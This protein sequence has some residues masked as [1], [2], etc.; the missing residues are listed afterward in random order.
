MAINRVPGGGSRPGVSSAGAERDA[1]PTQAQDE[2]E[3]TVDV[4]PIPNVEGSNGASQLRQLV[5]RAEQDSNDQQATLRIQDSARA[6]GRFEQAQRDQLPPSV[7]DSSL[8][9]QQQRDASDVQAL[10]QRA[11]GADAGALSLNDLQALIRAQE[12]TNASTS[13]AASGSAVTPTDTQQDIELANR[14]LTDRIEQTLQPRSAEDAWYE[15]GLVVSATQPMQHFVQQT[16]GVELRADSPPASA[17][18]IERTSGSSTRSLDLGN[19]DAVSGR[20][21]RND[22][23]A[24][25]NLGL[26]T[27]YVDPAHAVLE[28][29]LRTQSAS[30]SDNFE[31][32]RDQVRFH[33]A[34]RSAIRAEQDRALQALARLRDMPEGSLLSPPFVPQEIKVEWEGRNVSTPTTP[35]LPDFITV[36]IDKQT[37]DIPKAIYTKVG[38]NEALG[39]LGRV[40]DLPATTGGAQGCG[41]G[42]KNELVSNA[43]QFL[44]TNAALRTVQNGSFDYG[45]QGNAQMDYSAFV[46]ELERY[47][48]SAT[49]NQADGVQG[50]T[51]TLEGGRKVSDGVSDGN[52]DFK[53]LEWNQASQALAGA[54]GI[55]VQDLFANADVF[56]S[57]YEEIS[58]LLRDNNFDPASNDVLVEVLMMASMIEHAGTGFAINQGGM[59][60]RAEIEKYIDDLQKIAD[61]MG[62]V[63][64]QQGLDRALEYLADTYQTQ[65]ADLGQAGSGTA[66]GEA[67]PQGNLGS[68]PVQSTGR[69]ASSQVSG[70]GTRGGGSATSGGGRMS[71]DSI[72][73]NMASPSANLVD[74][75][76]LTTTRGGDARLSVIQQDASNATNR[77]TPDATTGLT[78][79]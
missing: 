10:A 3:P 18:A 35:P 6:A 58:T 76:G 51:V 32:L 30:S 34:V 52:L 54:I 59:F 33:H 2:A 12:N 43:F 56:N 50:G 72:L 37:L 20:G 73:A 13:G 5:Q 60:T 65:A 9:Q 41:T 40:R 8:Q 71:L 63:M 66:E 68:N 23:T 70:G 78:R 45:A 11:Q 16:M 55:E 57:Q 67:N 79:R 19:L 25:A 14:Q 39:A 29:A 74:N 4:E 1:A 69:Q 7:A 17:A 53:D 26:R 42:V 31:E 61:A 64:T 49:A 47:G 46:T 36:T 75:S 28:Q 22:S 77:L 21:A 24:T 15:N 44:A 27:G 38:F 62:G 48:I